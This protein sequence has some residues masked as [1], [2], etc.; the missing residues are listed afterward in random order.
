M[1]RTVAVLIAAPA[2]LLGAAG[3]ALSVALADD[4]AA[5]GN[6]AVVAAAVGV[7]LA[8]ALLLCV[9]RPQA[10]VGW[11][12][13]TGAVLWGVGEGALALGIHGLVADPGSVPGAAWVGVLGTSLRG[14]GWLD[15]VLLVPLLFPDG[16]PPWP[17]RR[18]PVWL[19]A[20]AIT[21]FLVATLVAPRP[22]EA[23][24]MRFDSPTG[25]PDSLRDLADTVAVLAIG[26]AIGALAV[27]VAGLVHRWRSGDPLLR[28]QLTWFGTAAVLPVVVLPLMGTSVVEPWMFGVATLPL[29]VAIAFAVLQRRLYDVQVVVSRTVTWVL[30]SAAVALLYAVTVGGVGALVGQQG[31][32]W[33]GYLAAG[34]VAVSFAPLHAALRRGANRMVLGRWSEPAD[35]LAATGLRLKDAADAPALLVTLVEEAADGLGLDAVWIT[36][37]EGVVIA[38][39]GAPGRATGGTP[40]TAYGEGVGRLDWRGAP[41]RDAQVRLLH[42]VSG[43]IGAVVHGAALLGSL[44][45]AREDLVRAREEERRRLRRDLHDGLGPE[46]AAL[47]MRVDTLRNRRDAEGVDLDAELVGLRG[48]IQSAVASVRRIV[49]GLRPPALDDLGIAAALEQVADGLPGGPAITVEVD[50]VPDLP[51]AAEVA[52]YRVAQEALTN[53]VRHSGASRA[54]VRLRAEDHLV[55]LSVTDDGSG[56]AA[57]RIDGL[58]LGSM[59]ERAA[60]VGGAVEVQSRPGGGTTVILR[61]PLAPDRAREGVGG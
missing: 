33:L 11:L 14:L 39:Q 34:V 16:R 21:T 30:V 35:A 54:C 55:V 31:A 37:A 1:G 5:E 60:E 10:R 36:D 3:A 49:E 25:L 24:L 13:L 47:T 2:A 58:G 7:Y 42:D 18:W 51:A 41:L 26:L 27:A 52:I 20:A 8:V 19:V 40:L 57:A 45:A 22:L 48:A 44:T 12:L 43:Q 29:P 53:V 17:G 23:T 38:A 61:V 15:L 46:L 6:R 32:P 28:Q 59:R 50:P 56:G 9:L 4:P